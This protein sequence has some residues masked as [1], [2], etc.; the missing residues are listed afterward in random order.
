MQKTGIWALVCLVFS[1]GL[2]LTAGTVTV[3][4]TA[5]YNLLLSSGSSGWSFS[6]LSGDPGLLLQSVTIDLGPTG[7]LAF[8]TAPGGFG[9]QGFQNIG[10]FNGTDVTTGLT[11]YTPAG[12]AALD[13]GTAVTF[14]FN[15]FRPGE[16]FQ[17]NADVDH[18]NPVLTNCAGKS[19]LALL[20]CNLGN[21]A[22]LT[23][24]QAVTANQMANA[25]VTFVFGGPGY[26]TGSSTG[27]FGPV[28]LQDIVNNGPGNHVNISTTAVATPEPASLSMIGGGL[29]LAAGLMRRKRTR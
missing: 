9:S 6:Y 8:D 10:S 11:G 12:G 18:P 23:S 24:A 15:D 22:A 1:G 26:V 4:A 7:G 27:T 20:A 2:T 19:G 13:G 17:F 28:T 29:L 3:D 5:S 14:T 16:T 25:N 21:T